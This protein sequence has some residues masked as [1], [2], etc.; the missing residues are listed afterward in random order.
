MTMT[1]DRNETR[2]GPGV[3]AAIAAFVVFMAIAAGAWCMAS[4][5]GGAGTEARILEAAVDEKPQV[6]AVA[7]LGGARHVVRSREF[8]KADAVAIFGECELDLTGAGLPP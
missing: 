7:F 6:D 2:P 5:Q 8:R 1:H 4:R 3:G